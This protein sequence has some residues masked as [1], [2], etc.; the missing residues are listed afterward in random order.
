MLCAAV[1]RERAI[2]SP[3]IIGGSRNSL[4]DQ[5]EVGVLK[6]EMKR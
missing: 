4:L 1:E 6:R 5:L 2:A 3:L